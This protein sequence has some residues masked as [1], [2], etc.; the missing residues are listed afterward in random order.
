MLGISM[1]M[2]RL[3]LL[4]LPRMVL[5]IASFSLKAKAI[6]LLLMFKIFKIAMATILI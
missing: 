6:T 4:V 3:I 5:T 2:V 1:E